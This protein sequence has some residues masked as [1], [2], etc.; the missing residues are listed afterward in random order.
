MGEENQ[1]NKL[2]TQSHSRAA[3]SREATA[4]AQKGSHTAVGTLGVRLW[5]CHLEILHFL[6]EG[7]HFL[8]FALGPAHCTA[9]PDQDCAGEQDKTP[10]F[11]WLRVQTGKAFKNY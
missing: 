6:I 5:C 10:L 9:S 1:V 4:G 3:L 7:P 2:G 11:M 8:H